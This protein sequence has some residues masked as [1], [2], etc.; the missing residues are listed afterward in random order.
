VTKPAVNKPT[1]PDLRARKGTRLVM[2]TAYDFPSAKIAVEAGV[3]VLLVGDSLG[4][5]V[6]GYDSTVPVTMEDMLHHTRATRRGAPDAFIIADMPFL[7]YATP[8]QAIAN[9]GRFLKEAGADSV[10]VEGGVDAVPV[11]EALVRAGVPV[12]GHIGL[13]PQTASSL[14]GYRLQG[15]DEAG[16]RRLLE[17]AV[18][19]ERAGCWG[20]VLE[21]IP[22]ALA[23][24]ITGR[25]GIPTVGIGAGPDCDGQVLVFH[26]LVGLFSGF[27]PKFAKRYAEA[28]ALMRE[29]I[30]RYVAEVKAG[31]YPAEEHS[32]GMDEA[33]LRRIYG[34]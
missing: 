2:L 5:V 21:L 6:L 23:R 13:T 27:T 18:A 34:G 28:G 31:A 1:V 11:I 15:R 32:F 33:V 10:K 8:A 17:D 16:A 3:E 26:D 12:L 19:I 14:G 29:G 7:A 24:A 25:V 9:A 4:M 30:S 20:I 22:A